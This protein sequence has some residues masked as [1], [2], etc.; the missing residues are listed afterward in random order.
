VNDY[1]EA[2]F[3]DMVADGSLDLEAIFFDDGDWYEIDTVEDLRAAEVMF[4][5]MG[6]PLAST[7]LNRSRYAG[8]RRA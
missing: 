4:A 7:S 3:S 1:Y 5:G 8:A 2:V 6:T